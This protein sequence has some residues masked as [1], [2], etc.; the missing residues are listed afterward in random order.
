MKDF[1]LQN[2]PENI[3]RSNPG[4]CLLFSLLWHGV[5]RHL[6]GVLTIR[7]EGSTKEPA[8]A[9]KQL[10][11]DFNHKAATIHLRLSPACISRSGMKT[12]TAT[13]ILRCC[14][15]HDCCYGDAELFGCHTKTDQY[16]WKCEEKTVK[17]GRA[18]SDLQAP[19]FL[20]L[21]RFSI[22]SISQHLPSALAAIANFFSGV[23][24]SDFFLEYYCWQ[25]ADR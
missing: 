21:R 7:W 14:H 10:W 25:M 23:G 5:P 17:C 12:L 18:F 1:L 6:S 24:L 9:L 3:P 22:V 13:L 11:C 4:R 19:S 15:R 2:R 8:P 20:T 16:W